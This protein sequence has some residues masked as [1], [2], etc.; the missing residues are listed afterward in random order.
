MKDAFWLNGVNR[1]SLG[2]IQWGIIWNSNLIRLR[3][4]ILPH[5]PEKLFCDGQL[6]SFANHRVDA[7]IGANGGV[8]MIAI[9]LRDFAGTKRPQAIVTP[10]ELI[11]R[12]L[13]SVALAEF[14]RANQAFVRVH[15]AFLLVLDCDFLLLL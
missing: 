14:V 4:P 1:E 13:R 11:L 6:G 10:A 3:K 12:K 7:A 15:L 8:V 2:H 5:L 9:P